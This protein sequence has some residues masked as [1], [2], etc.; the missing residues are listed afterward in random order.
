[1]KKTA[2][3]VALLTTAA[4][5]PQTAAASEPFC[6]METGNQVINLTALCGSTP[7]VTAIQH[8]V[9]TPE[10][11]RNWT[12]QPSSTPQWTQKIVYR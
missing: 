9:S 7:V 2:L 10:V 3:S 12:P 4:G 1:M 5:V 8:S 6:Y 11:I